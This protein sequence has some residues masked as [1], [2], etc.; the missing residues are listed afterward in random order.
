MQSLSFGNRNAWS[1][2]QNS[3]MLRS[4]RAVAY[5]V[6]LSTSA[7][8][9]FAQGIVKDWFNV[10]IGDKWVYE[11]TSRDEAG[12]G[13][14][15]LEIHT[16]R[17]EETTVG[18]R[19]IPEGTIVE[20]HVQVVAGSPRSRVSAS[21]IYLIRGSCLYKP[22]YSGAAWNPGTHTLAQD[23]LKGLGTYSSPDFC[24][25]LVV[26]KTWGAPHGLPD[27][28]VPRPED[29]RDW[30]VVGIQRNDTFAPD[31]PST[32]HIKS[33]S[34]YP[35]SGETV[36][37]WFEKDIGVVREVEIHHGTI[38]QERTRLIAFTPSQQ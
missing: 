7:G 4:C 16:W 11:H 14:A 28:N 18:T 6:L 21:E 26:N 33:I 12:E 20:R 17:T 34:A 30:Q 38:G 13:R 8:E 29:A 10:H 37:I 1:T 27:W 3:L 32:F 25:P 22:Q 35:G 24:F 5:L 36:D 23:F 31:R 15:H 2:R 9:A 19:V